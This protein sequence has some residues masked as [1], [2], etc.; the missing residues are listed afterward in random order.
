MKISTIYSAMLIPICGYIFNFFV[1][2]FVAAD[3]PEIMERNSP[4][5]AIVSNSH[6]LNSSSVCRNELSILEEGI[7]N[8]LIWSLKVLDTNGVPEPGF[9]T[10]NIFWLGLRS[11]CLD[12]GN[13][14]R[15]ETSPEL[16]EKFSIAH[17]FDEEFPPFEVN[18]FIA[19]AQHNATIQ[20]HFDRPFEDTINIGLC[21]PKSCSTKEISLILKKIFKEKTLIFTNVFSFNLNLIRVI[22]F[23][24]D[25]EWLYNWRSITVGTIL[26]IL[27]LMIVFGTIYDFIIHQ[28]RIE[29]FNSA[30]NENNSEETYKPTKAEKIL[31]GFSAY[32]N[33]LLI[34]NTKS[35]SKNIGAINGIKSMSLLFTF[36]AHICVFSDNFFDNRIRAFR[37]TEGMLAQLITNASL[38]VD[39]FLVVSGFL[40]S[41]SHFNR[42]E[43]LKEKGNVNTKFQ[44]NVLFH[45]IIKRFVRLTPVYMLIIGIAWMY[46]NWI[47]RNSVFEISENQLETCATYWWRNL[48]YINN[49]FSYKDVCFLWS[50][51]LSVDMHCFI[52]G[53]ILLCLSDIFFSLAAALTCCIMIGSMILFAHI[54]YTNKYIYTME[55]LAKKFDLIYTPTWIRINPYLIGMI[56]GYFLI[57]LKGKLEIEKKTLWALWIIGLLCIFVALFG[58]TNKNVSFTTAAIYV[59]CSRTVWA[60]GIAWILV[61]CSTNHAGIV[62]SFLSFKFW[63]PISRLT[64]SAY[65]LNPIVT[66]SIFLLSERSLHIEMLNLIALAL[67]AS[68]LTYACGFIMSIVVEIPM[69]LFF[70]N[71]L[72]L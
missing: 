52:I 71:C 51:Y 5:Y 56:T 2:D 27:F 48:L 14:R 46:Y 58:S 19:R 39:S 26:I 7:D 45:R 30:K 31:I 11:Q 21:L 47:T 36:L 42:R 66:Q 3:F 57:K 32:S 13:R 44:W 15:L 37:L 43:K 53:Q 20:F 1:I 16:F 17:K 54:S 23:E 25:Y 10:G 6:I 60:I 28:K 62:N 63:I 9:I 61:A 59:A 22:N 8:R 64:L 41:W 34:F 29:K 69:L 55:E 4:L 70:V 40:I 12:L 49:F 35:S 18:Y 72:G 50:W 67:G 38:F 65:L 33:S 24:N 68:F